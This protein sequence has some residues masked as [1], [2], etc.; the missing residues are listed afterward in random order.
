MSTILAVW[1]PE[2]LTVAT[3]MEKSFTS[4][5]LSTVFEGSVWVS[6]GFFSLVVSDGANPIIVRTPSGGSK[7]ARRAKFTIM[8][9]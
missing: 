9:G 3:S 7:F 1:E 4:E 8:V 5:R 2:P 6:I